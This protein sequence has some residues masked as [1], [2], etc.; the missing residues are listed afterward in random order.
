M[1]VLLLE[2][3]FAMERDVEQTIASSRMFE[4]NE[5]GALANLSELSWKLL[6]SEHELL[7]RI[8]FVDHLVMQ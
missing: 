1:S 4:R 8:V 7:E 6:L 5:Q 3:N 2:V